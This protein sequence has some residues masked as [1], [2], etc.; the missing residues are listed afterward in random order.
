M[1]EIEFTERLKRDFE[2]Y[3]PAG[4]RVATY[5]LAN[6][7]QLPYETADAIAA[8]TGLAGITVGRFLR[9]IGFKN[10]DDLKKSLRGG[11]PWLLTDRLGSFRAHAAQA[12]ALAQSLELEKR[13][14]ERTYA[15]TRSPEFQK[16]VQGI[17][18]ADAVFLAGIQSTRGIVTALSCLLEYIRPRVHYVDGLSGTY[19][20]SLNSECAAPYLLVADL[21]AYSVMTRRLCAAACRRG[22]PTALVVDQYC[23]WARSMPVDLLQIETVT[24]HFWDSLVPMCCLFNLLAD[25]VVARLGAKVDERIVRNKVLQKELGQFEF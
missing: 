4:K 21:S 14:L 8:Q 18:G 20:E 25:A 6:L 11:R 9:Q 19:L 22:I 15:L 12:D 10:L 7:Q 23:T 13:A 2:R 24:G 16:V 1:L 5:L 17:A 3:T